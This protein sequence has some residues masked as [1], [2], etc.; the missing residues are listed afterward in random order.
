MLNRGEV[1]RKR[2]EM[3]GEK[4]SGEG[5]AAMRRG[6]DMGYMYD[7]EKSNKKKR[8]IRDLVGKKK[9]ER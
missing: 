7:C 9:R 1:F 4:G 5:W 8:E 6:W 3:L 2:K